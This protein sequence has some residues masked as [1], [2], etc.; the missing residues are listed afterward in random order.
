MRARSPA[1]YSSSRYAS[2]GSA[3]SSGRLISTQCPPTISSA[4]MPIALERSGAGTPPETSG[5]VADLVRAVLV[6]QKADDI[7]LLQVQLAFGCAQRG[8]S[9]DDEEPLFVRVMSV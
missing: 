1:N 3:K 4:V 7:A 8:R 2:Q 5:A 9:A 6:S